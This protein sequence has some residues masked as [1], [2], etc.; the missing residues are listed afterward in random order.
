[1]TGKIPS[2]EAGFYVMLPPPAPGAHTLH[3]A[4]NSPATSP[5]FMLDVTYHLTVK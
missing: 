1:V 5:A 3:F 4:G 2:F